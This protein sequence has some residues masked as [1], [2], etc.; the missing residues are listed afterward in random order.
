MTNLTGEQKLIFAGLLQTHKEGYSLYKQGHK[1]SKK[2]DVLSQKLTD[3]FNDARTHSGRPELPPSPQHSGAS[4]HT[5]P[6]ARLPSTSKGAFASP[7]DPELL[8]RLRLPRP[9]VLPSSASGAPGL[10]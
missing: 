9:D 8:A 10:L 7:F 2:F 6:R 4:T 1:L 3:F 5:I